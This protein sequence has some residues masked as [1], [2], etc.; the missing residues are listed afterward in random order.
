MPYDLSGL[1]LDQAL[2]EMFPEFSRSR[3]QEWIKSGCVLVNGKPLRAK[4]K[5]IGGWEVALRAEL[6]EHGTDQAENIPLQIV[7]QDASLIIVDK[8][9]GL[10]V[11]PAAGHWDGTLVNAL[12]HFAPELAALPRAG[13][14]HRLDKDTSGLLMVARTLQAH[15]LLVDQLQA[16]DI[17]REYL[18]LVQGCVTAGGTVDAPLGRHPTDRKR[19]AVR[20]DGKPAVTHYRVAERF[21]QHTLLRLKLE[22]G[23]THQIRV[24]MAHLHYPVFGDPVYSRLRL[25]AGASPA[26]STCLQDFRR[27]ALHATRLA[28]THPDS[29]G[30]C[31]WH[32]ALPEDMQTL[33]DLLHNEQQA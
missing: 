2:V 32:S 12:L 7:Y 29:G 6:A 15:K 20:D 3:L 21:A 24:H 8:P 18:A 22:T 25:P 16:R 33:L 1:R 10:V 4:D 28:L 27:Q 17:E 23:R 31:E 13:I 19:F 9:A 14:V 11:H 5:V 26:L 30:Y